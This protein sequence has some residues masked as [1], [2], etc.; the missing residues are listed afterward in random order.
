MATSI[1]LSQTYFVGKRLKGEYVKVL[2]D[3]KRAHLT[4]YRH[5]RIS[6]RFPYP[7]LKH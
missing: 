4:V 2:L 6:K 7:F 3:T 1:L 5:G